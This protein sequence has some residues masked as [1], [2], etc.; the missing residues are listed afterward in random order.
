[1]LPDENHA[2]D[3]LK[4]YEEALVKIITGAWD[5]CWGKHKD[6]HDC[7]RTRA[8]IMHQFMMRHAKTVFAGE[9]S[10]QVIPGQETAY[11]LIEDRLAIRL[12]KGD[13]KH[14]GRNNETFGEDL[15]K[16]YGV[17]DPRPNLR[18]VT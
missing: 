7:K 11:F 6:L 15:K 2:K 4:P 3:V 16:L 13:E 5:D 8:C 14:L 10:V 9:P 17:R 18:V 1:M 12:K